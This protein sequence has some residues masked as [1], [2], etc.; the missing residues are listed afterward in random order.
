MQKGNKWKNSLILLMLKLRI[1]FALMLPRLGPI[2]L[3]HS[4]HAGGKWWDHVAPFVCQ[5]GK[6]VR[7]SYHACPSNLSIFPL[8]VGLSAFS[9]PIR[10]HLKSIFWMQILY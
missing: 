4:N 3:F 5:L 2:S 6:E 10:E 8:P 9:L 7:L 1:S